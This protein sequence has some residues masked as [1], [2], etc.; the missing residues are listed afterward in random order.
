MPGSVVVLG[1]PGVVFSAVTAS[2]SG[3][4]YTKSGPCT[5]TVELLSWN[6]IFI[7]G[8]FSLVWEHKPLFGLLKLK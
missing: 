3:Q 4:S 1:S 7:K 8:F 2:C 5:L 6:A